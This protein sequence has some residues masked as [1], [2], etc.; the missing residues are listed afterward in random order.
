MKMKDFLNLGKVNVLSRGSIRK[1]E[2]VLEGSLRDLSEE[3]LE[4]SF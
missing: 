2:R 3:I 4:G 1:D